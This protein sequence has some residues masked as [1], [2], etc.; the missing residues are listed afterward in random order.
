MLPH[1][2]ATSG[3]RAS[4]GYTL[5]CARKI[6]HSRHTRLTLVDRYLFFMCASRLP[7]HPETELLLRY[8]QPAADPQRWETV[9]MQKLVGA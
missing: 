1:V 8:D 6:G 5:G 4:G 2:G 9:L 7:L 3:L